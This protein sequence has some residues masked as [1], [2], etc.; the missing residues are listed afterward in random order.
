[1]WSCDTV[2]PALVWACLIP[3]TTWRHLFCWVCIISP[4]SESSEAT[5]E[6]QKWNLIKNEL[7]HRCNMFL[8][9]TNL[10]PTCQV[11]SYLLF[12]TYYNVLQNR[13]SHSKLQMLAIC[14][15]K[16][17]ALCARPWNIQRVSVAFCH[18]LSDY[19]WGSIRLS[20][21]FRFTLRNV[22]DKGQID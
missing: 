20:M 3:L 8:T 5:V 14:T 19:E 21:K 15:V 11:F 12:R 16:S 10:K 1:M 2:R 7:C 13:K 9:T 22:F 4:T 17:E 6:H 18:C